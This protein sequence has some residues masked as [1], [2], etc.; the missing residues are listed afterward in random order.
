MTVMLRS[1]EERDW[2]SEVSNQSTNSKSLG[3]PNITLRQWV[4]LK[5]HCSE[6]TFNRFMK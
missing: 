4:M 6:M 3:K 1:Y 5:E 2:R